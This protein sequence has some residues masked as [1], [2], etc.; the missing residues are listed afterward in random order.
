MK[1]TYIFSLIFSLLFIFT[2]CNDDLN[3]SRTDRANSAG[4]STQELILDKKG[5]GMSYKELTWSTRIGRLKPFWH[6]SW[7][8]DLKNNIPDSVEYVPMFWGA[9][10]VNDSE[11]TRIKGLINE[12][13]VKHVL[14]FNE[15]DLETQANMSVDEAIALW[16]KFFLSCVIAVKDGLAKVPTT[17]PSKVI[18]DISLPIFLFN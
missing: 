1:N 13:K 12:G 4:T 2:N 10:S 7:N 18:I 16:P 14:G 11:I 17:G 8:R 3:I 5:I 9:N 6:Y 15:P